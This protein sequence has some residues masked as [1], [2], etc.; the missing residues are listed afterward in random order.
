[1]FLP[2]PSVH[3]ASDRIHHRPRRAQYPQTI[4]GLNLEPILCGSRERKK[5]AGRRTPVF[6]KC[7]DN[8][9][10]VDAGISSD[11]D[12]STSGASSGSNLI[13]SIIRVYP[14]LPRI[15]FHFPS[16]ACSRILSRP[17]CSNLPSAYNNS[18]KCIRACHLG[19]SGGSTQIGSNVPPIRST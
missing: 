15:H 11:T 13:Q 19:Y 7:P 4:I 10:T 6:E 14:H 17:S 3:P 5:S 8:R 16:S 2:G 1:V 18:G 12:V 9:R